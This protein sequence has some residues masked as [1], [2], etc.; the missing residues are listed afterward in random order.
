MNENDSVDVLVVGAGP[1]GLSAAIALARQ[2]RRVHVVERRSAPSTQPR[3]HVINARTMEIFSHWGVADDIVAAGLS[4]ELAKSFSWSTTMAADALAT[5]DYVSEEDAEE[6]SPSRLCSCPQDL[7]EQTLLEKLAGFPQASIRFGEELVSLV[8]TSDRIVSTVRDADGQHDVEARYVIG[9]DGAN[10]TVRE[11]VDAGLER[12]EPLGRRVNIY[13]HSDLSAVTRDRPNILWFILSPD[14]SGIFIALDGHSR[15]VYSVEV[16]ADTDTASLFT[17]EHCT[18]VLRLATGVADLRP[19]IQSVLP[20]R[21]DMAIADRWRTGR[22]FLAGDSAHQFPPM[23]GF[24]MN[25]GI[26]DAHNLA[27]KLDA[28]LAGVGG[29]RLLD[30]YAEERRA[31]SVFNANRSMQNAVNQQKAVE[32]MADPNVLRMLA[33]P[34]GDEIRAIFASGVAQQ[35]EEFH[36]QGQQFG[37]T[38]TS[39]AVVPDGTPVPESTVSFYAQSSHPGARAPYAR[40]RRPDGTDTTTLDVLARGW[41]VLAIGDAWTDA[42]ARAARRIGID[43][44][45]VPLAPGA[46][47]DPEGHVAQRYGLD[48]GGAV[49]VRPDGHVAARWAAVPEEVD[50]A[51]SDALAS[52]LGREHV[53][54]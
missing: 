2:G 10:S 48:V 49:L 18:S 17:P 28:V 36:S 24:G 11:L 50:G 6:N 41:T 42:V 45:P 53:M 3:A 14:T 27:W 47:A 25:S 21:V 44:Q 16:D 46:F 8:Q 19:E 37:F 5:L 12:S 20:W 4:P 13:F 51:L 54:A 40:L 15:W 1:V 26:Q 32:F 30:S 29:D 34:E 22:I 43:I 9:A 35:R 52:V 39:S 7:I 38:Y 23:G 33:A 31:V